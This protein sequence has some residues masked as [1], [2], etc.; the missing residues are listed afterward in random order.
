MALLLSLTGMTRQKLKEA[1]QHEGNEEDHD[2]PE[3]G[4]DVAGQGEKV[5]EFG[6]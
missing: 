4:P 2:C 5:L 3:G 1:S 6:C